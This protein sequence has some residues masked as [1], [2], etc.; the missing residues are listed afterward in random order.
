M[1][2][3]ALQLLEEVQS[4]ISRLVGCYKQRRKGAVPNRHPTGELEPTS[5][6]LVG[7]GGGYLQNMVGHTA[8]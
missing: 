7:C 6:S 2:A 5:G 3:V 1:L 8:L 4:K